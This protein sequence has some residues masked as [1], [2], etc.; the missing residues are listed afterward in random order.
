MQLPCYVKVCKST[1]GLTFGCSDIFWLALAV[2]VAV[3][4]NTRGRSSAVWVLLAIVISPLLAGLLLLALPRLD[5][6][7]AIFSKIKNEKYL[8]CVLS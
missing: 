1:E 4:A 2:I 6:G 5:N 8:F 3:A 7:H